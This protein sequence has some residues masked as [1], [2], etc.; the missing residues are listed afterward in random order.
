MYLNILK[1]DLKRKKTM[2]II[3][4][5]FIILATT[6][7]SGSVNNVVSITTA[8]DSYFDMAGVP[9][10]TV[11]TMNKGATKN[12]VDVLNDI[13]EVESFGV[14][15][16]LFLNSENLKLQGN[17]VN[18][19]N[20]VVQSFEGL[21]TEIYDK[22]NKPVTE[23]KE[24]EILL[25]EKVMTAYN[26]AVGDKITITI[27]EVEREF[28]VKESFKD[29]MYGGSMV[30]VNRFLITEKEFD[31]Y[32]N[33]GGE[34]AEYFKGNFCY[35]TTGDVSAVSQE[36]N[37]HNCG[38]SFSGGPD[39]FKMTYV[40]NMI[41]AGVLLV[42][43]LC[44][45]VVSF[46]VLRFTIGFTMSEEYREIGVMKAIGIRDSKI[47]GLYMIKYLALSVIGAVVGFFLSMPLS[48]LMLQSIAKT[49]VISSDNPF[50]I[51]GGCA[52]FV[53]GVILL[54][55]Y[56]CTGKTKKY[57]PVDAIRS[58][59]TGKRFKKKGIVYL[60]KTPLK[61]TVFLAIND[62]FSNPKRFGI[63]ALVFMLCLSML[64]MLVNSANTLKSDSLISSFAMAECDLCFTDDDK[65]MSFMVEDGR[66]MAEAELEEV[67]SK[68]KAAGM[69]AQCFCEAIFKFTAVKGD[70]SFNTYTTIGV[71]A[72]TDMYKYF[73]GTAPENANEIAITPK[74]AE[75]IDASIGDTIVIKQLEGDREYIVTALYQS[76]MNMGEGIRFHEDNDINFIQCGGYLAF[77]LKFDEELTD[78]EIRGRKDEVKDIVEADE[79]YTAGE[80]V[81]N[82]SGSSA[83]IDA[84]SALVLVLTIIVIVLIAVLM[85]RSFV[86]KEK[87]EIALLKAVG[88][89]DSS[90]IWWHTLRF[91]I[92]AVVSSVLAVSLTVPLT[93][94]V[95]DPVFNMMGASF[96]IDY[97]I[98]P[99][100]VYVI[101][102][103]IVIITTLISA[104]LASFSTKS[105][106]ASD[107]A[108]I[109]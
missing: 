81:D 55:C 108:G 44:L 50:L 30:S 5:L 3:L 102:P 61:P 23:L 13:E 37:N 46:V 4:L 12:V 60:N 90:V 10:Y 73:E 96:G 21:Q 101:Y 24:G 68:L 106:K 91:V 105:I 51:N 2:N 8:L 27:G 94:L 38:V 14:E 62:V 57:T 71:G 103:A 109:E 17:S 75:S 36:L 20:T 26:I 49:I 18:I 1:K 48:D 66:E 43:S 34:Y 67:E 69:S 19:S 74:V 84:V 88:I 82:I 95:I 52:L 97:E 31:A 92:V 53:I 98:V 64:L 87:G 78:A 80:Y 41:V 100:E 63:I 29:A 16:V 83:M 85:E 65:Q 9:D 59:E 28:T 15:D 89:K 40:L 72:T 6:F 104:F 32:F 33:G 47:R 7:V 70:K 54:F 76:M 79:I 22:N 86:A 93:H 25:V 42:V 77:Q 58:G 107:C 11:I 99:L 39:L 56:I 45:I 35:V